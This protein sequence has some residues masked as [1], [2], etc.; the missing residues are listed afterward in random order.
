MV[1]KAF[2]KIVYGLGFA[3]GYVAEVIR[4]IFTKK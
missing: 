3:I 4:S 1:R 2:G